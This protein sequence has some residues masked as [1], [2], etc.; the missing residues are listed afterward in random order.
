EGPEELTKKLRDFVKNVPA[1]G[2]L[3]RE[4]EN[5]STEVARGWI[6]AY[7]DEHPDLRK[8]W[9]TMEPAPAFELGILHRA[10]GQRVLARDDQQVAQADGYYCT[11]CGYR[12]GPDPASVLEKRRCVRCRTTYVFD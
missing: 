12:F 11:H 10:Q 9:R 5:L 4:G 3:E 8:L 2:L 6:L 1:F 7:L